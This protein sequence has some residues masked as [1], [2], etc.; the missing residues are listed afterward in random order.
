MAS[1]G[2][3]QKDGRHLDL[4]SKDLEQLSN[5]ADALGRDML[6]GTKRNAKGQIAYRIQFSDVAYYDFLL[7]VG[8]TPAKSTTIDALRVPDSFYADFLRG[9]FDGDGSCYGFID[10]RWQSSFMFYTYFAS[11]SPNFINYLRLNN[12]R[13]AGTSQ[14]SINSSSRALS[15][16]YAKADSR[17]LFNF[18]YYQG[19]GLCLT[20]KKTKLAAFVDRDETAIIVQR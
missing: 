18:M 13:L 16:T 17:K 14:G 19:H 15:L 8:L 4:T 3:L 1:D 10:K 11:A 5:F 2:C 6:I 9:L 7:S 20:R 12:T